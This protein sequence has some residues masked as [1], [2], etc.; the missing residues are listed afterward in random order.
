MNSETSA[1]H[2]C[3]VQIVPYSTDVRYVRG[4][5]GDLIICDDAEDMSKLF[6]FSVVVP[7][8]LVAGTA[9][10]VCKTNTSKLNTKR[11]RES[12]GIG[13]CTSTEHS[14]NMKNMKGKKKED[15]HYSYLDQ[16]SKLKDNITG[17]YMFAVDT[18]YTSAFSASADAS[19]S[20]S[21]SASCN[22]NTNTNTMFK[23]KI[24]YPPWL[25]VRK[26][27]RLM[28]MRMRIHTK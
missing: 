6:Y 2:C 4:V 17:E 5:G 3:A 15:G 27:D 11:S 24:D 26:L 21:A 10:I 16:Q 18:F 8:L 23:F 7:L 25:P 19:A 1:F 22:T 14:K 20:A 12:L 28:R 13:T 9:L